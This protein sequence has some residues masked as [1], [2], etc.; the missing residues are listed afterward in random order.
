MFCNRVSASRFSLGKSAS[1]HIPDQGIA[2]HAV[3]VNQTIAKGNDLPAAGDVHG[4]VGKVTR[5][6]H[7]SF[8]DDLK[9]TLHGAFNIGL[10][11]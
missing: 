4:N 2:D 1:D 8:A 3:A 5:Q 6:L 9:L 11:E 10:A 7:Q